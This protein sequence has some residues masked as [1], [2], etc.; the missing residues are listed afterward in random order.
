MKNRISRVIV[1]MILVVSV[2]VFMAGCAKSVNVTVNTQ[3]SQSGEQTYKSSEGWSVQYDPSQITVKEDNGTT[4]FIYTG[5]KT[6]TDKLTISYKQGAQPEET[7]DALAA[8]WANNDQVL[9]SESYFPGTTDKW[10]YWRSLPDPKGTSENAF[11]GQYND[12]VLIFQT[13][14]AGTGNDETDRTIR[15]TLTGVMDSITYE[16]FGPQQMYAG[17]AGVYTMEGTGY[18]VTLGEDHSGE[19]KMGD[20]DLYVMWGTHN[21]IQADNSYDY[22]TDGHTLNVNIDGNDLVFTK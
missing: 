13:T 14:I 7:A 19:I 21:L 17:I 9:N 15:D 3:P 12:G 6:G 18:T 16:A 22:S 10:G 8:G 20:N 4:S 11:V 5:D 2:M 1:S